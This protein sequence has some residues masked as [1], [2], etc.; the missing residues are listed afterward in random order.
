MRVLAI[1]TAMLV[2]PV[3]TAE[4]QSSPRSSDVSTPEGIVNALYETV[5]RRPGENFD[6]ARQRSLFLPTARLIPNLEQTGGE[7]RVLTLEE[8]ISWVDE[9]TT[10]GGGEDNGFE[11]REVAIVVERF[12]DIAHAFSTYEKGFYGLPETLGRG[13]NSIQMIRRDGR[14]WIT[15]I[16]WDE[17]SPGKTVPPRYMPGTTGAIQLP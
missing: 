15:Q 8:F 14:W 16:V 3:G 17:E 11:E 6:W 9:H 10:V 5:T 1:L 7:L 13:I 2:L 12:G 4:G